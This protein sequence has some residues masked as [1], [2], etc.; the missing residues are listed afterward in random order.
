MT[1]KQ[2]ITL[3]NFILDETGSM[4]SC[5]EETIS[6]F[7]EYVSTLKKAE[8]SFQMS[9]TK[10]NS[11]KTEI[12]FEAQDIQKVPELSRDTYVPADLTPLYDAVGIT[13]SRINSFIAQKKTSKKAIPNIICVIMTDGEENASKEYTREQV[14]DLVK[15][16]EKEG[17]T[18][19]FLGANQDAWASGSQIGLAQGNTLS[20]NTVD[21]INTIRSLGGA[22]TAYA[23]AMSADPAMSNTT[24]FF[25]VYYSKK[26]DK[27]K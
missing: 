22:T 18:F 5:R 21:T 23:S 13:V 24:N 9:L 25:D 26:K 27:K 11:A 3:V 12:V 15:E 2:K 1:K 20:Y 17:W 6:G 10:F 16:H 4:E 14:F 7:N 19:L 8:T